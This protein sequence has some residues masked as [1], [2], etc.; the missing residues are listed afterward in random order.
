MSTARSVTLAVR[1]VRP[2]LAVSSSSY[3]NLRV[4]QV[5]TD[6]PLPTVRRLGH[7]VPIAADDELLLRREERAQ[8]R[9]AVSLA[10][11]EVG[12]GRVPCHRKRAPGCHCVGGS[13]AVL[14][15][16][17]GPLQTTLPEMTPNTQ[18]TFRICAK[19]A[20]GV[21]TGATATLF[22]NSAAAPEV[23]GVAAASAT[24]TSAL[25]TWQYAGPGKF[26]VTT[27]T[28]APPA[29]C[30]LGTTTSNTQLT[31]SG[32]TPNSTYFV[33]VCALNNDT[34]PRATAGVVASFTTP[35]QPSDF[36]ITGPNVITL[37]LFGNNPYMATI[38]WTASNFA[39][40]GYY[41]ALGTSPTCAVTYWDT[42]AGAASTSAGVPLVNLAPT[43]YVCVLARGAGNT[44]RPAT[45]NG[46]T[47][48]TVQP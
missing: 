32:L 18:Y 2:G 41:V 48:A 46:R 20:T 44:T 14:S 33:R 1:A 5:V 30:G 23:E 22:L 19:N 45:N 26:R 34:Q 21:S 36:T 42:L 17:P 29:R 27:S 9:R 43:V 38:T 39:T 35:Q 13:D 47:V 16:G 31:L 37:G 24:A 11:D 15:G 12:D 25:V 10:I 4:L 6:L 7:T 28:A 8:H 40:Q 3:E